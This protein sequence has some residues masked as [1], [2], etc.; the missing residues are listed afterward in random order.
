MSNLKPAAK[1]QAGPYVKKVIGEIEAL[2]NV[3]KLEEA[4]ALARKLH[5]E[6]PDRADVNDTLSLT[7]ADQK[8]Y[9]SALPF[10]EFA[11]KKEP[12]NPAYLVNLGR[13]YL[14]LEL[15]EDALPVL[16][17]AM[18]C[19][20]VPFQ[21]SW[22][23]AEF[24]HDTGKAERALPYFEKA[25]ETADPQSKSE[26]LVDQFQCL[27]SLG[28]VEQA[29][30][31]LDNLEPGSRSQVINPTRR[32]S[33][34]KYKTDSIIFE[35]LKS[36]VEGGRVG[37]EQKAMAFLELG[38]IYENSKQ[39]DE[40]FECFM[41]SKAE[42]K[43]NGDIDTFIADV[44]GHIAAFTP[45][46]FAKY[47]G[48]G[49]ASEQPV[50]VVGMPR[51]GT[52]LTEQIIGAHAEAGGVGELRRMRTLFSGF[53]RS[54]HPEDLFSVFERVGLEK[55][56]DVPAVYLRL[57]NYLSPGKKRIVDKMPHNFVM[58]GFISLCFPR[59]RIVHV[60][61]NPMDNFIS[62]FQ[63]HMNEF[64]GY[65]FEQVAY[66][67]YYLH[68]QRL[69]AHWNAVLPE[70]I[71]DLHYDALVQEPEP[72]VRQLIDFVGL[73]WSDECLRFH[74]KQ[75]T[76]RTFSKHQVRSAVNANSLERWRN[77]ENHLGPLLDMLGIK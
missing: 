54:G 64:H 12:R 10:A 66:G 20:P 5:G 39:F 22:A 68:Y 41:R 28:R 70:R 15:I 36:L 34:R 69:M 60:R 14:D 77:Y 1:L 35:E 49:S 62:A 72:I 11:A 21:A 32:A 24:F 27:A 46:V 19:K 13:L 47:R 42:R 4:E 37:T 26:I 71:F 51:S 73:E 3:G 40:A 23:I 38:K 18:T 56:R 16:E 31:L 8:R 65:S 76:V 58:V 29:E 43:W 2:G 59:A 17:S 33:L 9:S 75:T 67:K 44:N 48:F 25:L 57:L 52:T 7:L 30:Q 53:A 55:W 63:N 45:E 61:R 50:F 74:E 6:Y